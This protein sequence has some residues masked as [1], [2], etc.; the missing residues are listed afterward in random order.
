MGRHFNRVEGPD[1][2]TAVI[3]RHSRW[4]GVVDISMLP[5]LS[6]TTQPAASREVVLS[7]RRS[8]CPP[9]RAGDTLKPWNNK[10]TIYGGMP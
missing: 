1:A 3:P 10:V 6:L 5:S 4:S 8:D 2:A 9:R 7:G